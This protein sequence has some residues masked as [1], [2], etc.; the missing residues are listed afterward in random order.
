MQKDRLTKKF[1]NQYTKCSNTILQD[2]R[3]SYEAIG[4]FA[5]LWSKNDDWDVIVRHL[6]KRNNTTEYLV[7]KALRELRDCGYMKWN[8]IQSGCEY[9]MDDDGLFNVDSQH[10]D[11]QHDDSQHDDSQHDDSQHDDS[12]HVDSQHVDSQHDDSQHDIYI[13]KKDSN[14]INN[15][16][17]KEKYKKENSFTKPSRE[18]VQEYIIKKK[19]PIS[20]DSVISY[21]ESTNWVK[22][23]GQ[24]VLNWK[25]TINNWTRPPIADRENDIENMTFTVKEKNQ[26]HTPY[27][28]LE[29]ILTKK[30]MSRNENEIKQILQMEGCKQWLKQVC[31]NKTFQVTMENIQNNIEAQKTLKMAYIVF[32]EKFKTSRKQINEEIQERLPLFLIRCEKIRYTAVI[33]GLNTI[34]KNDYNMYMQ[35]QAESKLPYISHFDY[36]IQ[37]IEAIDSKITFSLAKLLKIIDAC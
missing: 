4:I 25:S 8:R 27:Q 3:L 21:Y 13:Q 23:N 18:E 11:S 12:Q 31:D 33:E 5:Y 14:K 6:Q 16:N 37:R 36:V 26:N 2:S 19:L 32:L 1:N 34:T 9:F 24:P 7:R 30:G 17:D 35:K 10:D 22:K 29:T 28:K 15:I 20:A